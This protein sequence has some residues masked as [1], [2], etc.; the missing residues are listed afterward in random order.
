MAWATTGSRH[1]GLLDRERLRNLLDEAVTRQVTVI[2]APPG[3]G[4]TSLLRTWLEHARNAYRI[5]F[6][7]GRGDEDEQGFWL[8]LLAQLQP[9]AGPPTPVFN[10]AAMVNRVLSALEANNAPTLL[11]LD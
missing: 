2:S 3:S 10:G 11:I 9:A 5:V 4:K 6:V 1:G 7:S 8:S